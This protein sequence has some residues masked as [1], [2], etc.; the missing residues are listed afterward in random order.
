[1]PELLKFAVHSATQALLSLCKTGF[2][3]FSLHT[4]EV[5]DMQ[6]ALLGPDQDCTAR[7][8]IQD[9]A[10][11]KPL[12]AT[13]ST[14]NAKLNKEKRVPK[15]VD[16]H[17]TGKVVYCRHLQHLE[18]RASEFGWRVC[19]RRTAI[20]RSQCFMAQ[21]SLQRSLKRPLKPTNEDE[22]ES[23]HAA[24]QISTGKPQKS[25][26]WPAAAAGAV[27]VVAVVA[28]VLFT[29]CCA[30]VAPCFY[31]HDDDEESTTVSDTD[32]EAPSMVYALD[33]ARASPVKLDRSSSLGTRAGT[34]GRYQRSSSI[35]S[36]KADGSKPRSPSAAA[37]GWQEGVY[38]PPFANGPRTTSASDAQPPAA[39][40][41]GSLASFSQHG[42]GSNSGVSSAIG[43]L[44]A[45][46]A[47]GSQS[48]VL[49][50]TQPTRSSRASSSPSLSVIRAQGLEATGAAGGF[51]AVPANR[52]TS[53][54]PFL[55]SRAS[56]TH[57]V[58]DIAEDRPL[59]KPA[60]N[61]RSST[62]DTSGAASSA[63]SSSA[64]HPGWMVS[65][66]GGEMLD[67]SNHSSIRATP[68][69]GGSPLGAYESSKRG[70][71]PSAGPGRAASEEAKQISPMYGPKRS[72]LPLISADLAATQNESPSA[73]HTM[74]LPTLSLGSAQVQSGARARAVSMGAT[75]H[76]LDL[77]RGYAELHIETGSTAH[78]S[79]EDE[80]EDQ[81]QAERGAS[82]LSSHS[83]VPRLRSAAS[84]AVV[85]TTQGS[86]Y[87]EAPPIQTPNM[88]R[89]RSH[90]RSR[91]HGV[92]GIGS[93]VSLGRRGSL[94][95]SPPGSAGG[96]PHR[97]SNTSGSG[98]PSALTSIQQLVGGT[99][100]RR[101]SVEQHKQHN[102]S[103]LTTRLG[104][105][106]G[107][108]L[109]DDAAVDAPDTLVES[110]VFFT[111]L[112]AS[113]TKRVQIGLPKRDP[114]DF[115]IG[116]RTISEMPPSHPHGHQQSAASASSASPT[117]SMPEHLSSM[118]TGTQSAGSLMNIRLG[119]GAQ[120]SSNADPS[121]TAGTPG[122]HHHTPLA[123]SALLAKS[124]QGSLLQGGFGSQ[125]SPPRAVILSSPPEAKRVVAAGFSRA[126]SVE[127]VSEQG[128]SSEDSPVDLSTVRT[129][130][131]SLST[132]DL[133]ET[134]RAQGELTAEYAGRR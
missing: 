35:A 29:G 94:G 60:P 20:S 3:K 56:P 67:D 44:A 132:N 18:G 23:R 17:A 91:S 46:M 129:R 25:Q 53:L 64:V 133:F 37:N 109:P 15:L 58:P 81:P 97:R 28:L 14:P 75:H 130:R 22:S 8:S 31:I 34:P 119:M 124:S 128:S 66:L 84:S 11:L 10:A 72:S 96:R 40:T 19:I 121:P 118:G 77:P 9:A 83:D 113:P 76:N 74:E 51:S 126:R 45:G 63:A 38:T 87:S 88:H 4:N 59:P 32:A 49:V 27:V 7:T 112:D 42:S 1:M 131:T 41:L 115:D 61:L 110:P 114:R 21:E 134:E 102:S 16:L 36:E 68:A 103:K 12:E 57:R 2:G 78:V 105:V 123:A 100:A 92:H 90:S 93:P 55:H 6:A 104:Q 33:A 69:K 73:S 98:E 79:H 43:L 47:P 39:S 24:K 80:L 13:L 62:L 5:M 48:S 111:P 52:G 117:H 125:G 50:G 120:N 107:R 116:S 86:K 108:Q 65:A 70:R 30:K 26:Y 122:T 99:A 82:H 101:E 54:S 95:M 127:H 85:S 106:S 89:A 71:R